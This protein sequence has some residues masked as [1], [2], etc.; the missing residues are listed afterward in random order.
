MKRTLKILKWI[1]I[2]LISIVLLMVI[3]LTFYTLDASKP[4]DEMYETIE[5][6]DRTDIILTE[7]FDTYKLSVSNPIANIIIIPGGKVY[8][9]SY[10]YLAYQLACYGY[11]VYLTKALFHLA[12]LNPFGPSKYISNDLPNIIIGHSLG[13]TVGSMIAGSSNQIDH[14]IL[15]AS[16][17]SNKINDSDVL[18]ITAEHDLVLNQTNFNQSLSNYNT[19]V[20]TNIA[21]G[22]HAGFGWYGVQQ[23]DGINSITIKEQQDLTL[24]IIINYLTENLS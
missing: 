17:A 10:F 22:N 11:Q 24:D 16:Y 2:S 15:L 14:L 12:I 5:T 23:G 3:G 9:E 20:H 1:L 8:T 13:G 7:D 21:G 4:L 18:L 19:Y 6:L